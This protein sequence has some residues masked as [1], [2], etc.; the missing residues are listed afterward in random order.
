[1]RI[2][3]AILDELRR[4]DCLPRTARA[5]ARKLQEVIQRLEQRFGRAPNDEE[6]RGELELSPKEFKR[7]MSRVRPIS[8]VS[9]DG[10]YANADPDAPDLH[11]S[12]ADETHT[13]CFEKMQKQELITMIGRKIKQLPE[14]QQKILA[15]YYFEGMRLAEI[16]EVFGVTEA[17]I[18]QIQGQALGQLRKYATSVMSR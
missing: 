13:P 3:G 18:C 4:L 17:R 5:K 2:R 14:R 12:I 8:F 1:M 6:I 16:A 15:M 11:E 7:M 10:A 9:L